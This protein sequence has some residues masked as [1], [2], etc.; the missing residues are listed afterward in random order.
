MWEE[1]EWRGCGELV[2]HM[3]YAHAKFSI[4]EKSSYRSFIKFMIM[5]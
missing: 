3:F 4:N 2:G 5:H 1:L